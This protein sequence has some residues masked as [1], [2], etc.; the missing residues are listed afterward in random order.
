MLVWGKQKELVCGSK[1]TLG[2]FSE[3]LNDLRN[4]EESL[5][6]RVFLKNSK[7]VL[8]EKTVGRERRREEFDGEH[9]R[10]SF[11]IQQILTIPVRMHTM[12]R[13][14]KKNKLEDFPLSQCL[15]SKMQHIP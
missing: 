14:K 15:Q 5:R 10:N 9:R 8:Q 4:I 1:L 11:C 7:A 2:I 3:S 13:K 6:D 12:S